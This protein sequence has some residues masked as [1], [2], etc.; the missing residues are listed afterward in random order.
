MKMHFILSAVSAVSL[1]WAQEVLTLEKALMHLKEKNLF[2][3]EAVADKHIYQGKQKYAIGEFDTLL[4]TTYEDKDYPYST[5]SFLDTT[6]EKP[7]ENGMEFMLGFRKA[8]GIQEYNNIKTGEEGELLAGVKIPIFSVLN[9]TSDRKANLKSA[10][11]DA[12]KHSFKS[13]NKL[14]QLHFSV[15]SHYHKLLYKKT[16]LSLEKELLTAAQQREGFIKKKVEI[17]SLPRIALLEAKQQIINRQQRFIT[18]Q[19]IFENH[20][21]SFLRYLNIAQDTFEKKYTLPSMHTIQKKPLTIHQAFTQAQKNRP[22]LK[23]FDYELK[24]FNIHQQNTKLLKYPNLNLSLYGVHDFKYDNG[25]KVSLGMSFPIERRKYEGKYKELDERVKYV[26]NGR[27]KRL[28]TIKTELINI[29]NSLNNLATNIKNSQEEVQLVEKLEE[30]ENKK[31]T[32]GLSNL[33]MV[34]QREVY[35]LNIKKKLLKYRLQ[36]LLLEQKASNEM[37]ISH[38]SLKKK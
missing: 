24:K 3:N 15:A 18:A 11:F 6:L 37:G 29:I 38:L 20:L 25:F 22:D 7:M 5:G 31:Y 21:T 33:F 35:T 19:N 23:V 26:K 10:I 34:N 1:L 14:R 17:G 32:A 2:F 30:S 9:N 12:Q 27:K 36:H 16:L 13:D 4:S 28:L 8:E